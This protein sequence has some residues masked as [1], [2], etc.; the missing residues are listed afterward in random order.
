MFK[1][2]FFAG[3]AAAF[4]MPAMAN[5]AMLPARQG[6][7]AVVTTTSDSN[8]QR[9]ILDQPDH[10]DNALSGR[11]TGYAGNSGANR[12]RVSSDPVGGGGGGSPTPEPNSVVLFAIGLSALILLENRRT[13]SKRRQSEASLD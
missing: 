13:A 1:S 4:M 6:G 10:R 8:V 7:T 11:N 12:S 3:I 2:V 5:A 9:I